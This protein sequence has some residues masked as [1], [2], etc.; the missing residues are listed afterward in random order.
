M[1]IHSG[2]RIY[3]TFN[4]I[5]PITFDIQAYVEKEEHKQTGRSRLEMNVIVID[6]SGNIL[7]PLDQP[8]PRVQVVL[9]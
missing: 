7:R 8:P 4:E 9:T 5:G 2:G 3:S 6:P 1:S